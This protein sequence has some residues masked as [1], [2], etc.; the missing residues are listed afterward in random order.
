MKILVITGELSG[1]LYAYLLVKKLRELLPSLYFIGIGG[2][3]LR[4]LDVDILFS[5]EPLSLVGI[6]DFSRLKRYLFVLNRIKDLLRKRHV[7]LV[8]LVDFPGFNLRI[9]KFAK[10]LGYPVVYFVA[11]QV[12]AWYRR[13]IHLLRK[14]VDLLYVVLPFEE[15]FFKSY[16]VRAKYFGHPLLDV[17]KPHLSAEL[18]YEVYGLKENVP[19]I[20]FFPG[21]RESEVARHIP[22]FL[23]VYRRLKEKNI[24]VQGLM[25]KALGL[26][27]SPLWEEARRAFKVLESVQYDVL[28]HSDLAVLASGTITLEA[29]LIGTPSVVVYSLP[30]LVYHLAKR[31]VKVPFISLPNLIL[32]KAIYPEIIVEREGLKCLANVVEELLFDEEKRREMKE[33]LARLPIEVGPPGAIRRIAE[34]FINFIELFKHQRRP[35]TG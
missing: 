31:L 34:D 10:G 3:R 28:K 35:L 26:R 5:A 23:E 2:P 13:R 18:F 21:S 15:E 32:Q 33:A 19:I 17:V 7:D 16:G 9:A 27:E 22:I 6:P 29:G 12:W 25:V 4:S 1:D 11:P 8:L 30:P 24:E 14:Y 20:S